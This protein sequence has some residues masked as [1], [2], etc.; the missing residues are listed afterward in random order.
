M[1]SVLRV[2]SVAALLVVVA[3]GC[4]GADRPSR[5]AVH[6]VPPALAQAWEGQASAIAA[7]ASA[8]NSC[9]A[10]Q[11]ANALRSDVI[12]N[13]HKLPRRLRS[14]LFSGVNA[15]AGRITCVPTV[16]KPPKKS[17]EPPHEHHGKH[18]HH[19]H[20]KGDAGGNEQ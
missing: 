6:G 17:P 13:Q 9:H 1:T 4:G 8:G 19:G 12:A 2:L 7:A 20:G 18:D 15:L 16:Q 5:A 11:L 14:P 10:L 3:A